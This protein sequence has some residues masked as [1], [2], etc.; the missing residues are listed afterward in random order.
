MLGE[1]A[2][3]AAA[4]GVHEYTAKL[5]LC[6]CMSRTLREYYRKAGFSEKIWFT[7]MCDLKYKA[8]ECRLVHGIW[9]SFVSEWFIRF[10]RMTRF[11][12]EK[13]QFEL[14]SFEK[15]Y[16][17]NG[18][19]LTPGSTVIN[20]HIPRT[21]GRLDEAGLKSSFKQA[22]AFFREN[23]QTEPIVFVCSS[24]LLFPKNLEVLS[25]SSNLYRF[26][27][28]FDLIAHGEYADYSQVWRLFD[29][30][31]QGDVDQLPQDTSFRRAYA[32]W[33]R[34]GE[35]TGWGDG[36]YVYSE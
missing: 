8:V 23:F 18:V 26:I 6:L 9:G 36:V 11:G 31:Y 3:L 12:F 4:V 14:I 7:C 15:D 1:A 19:C 20:V 5:L 33:I 29:K 25:P 2:A 34:K 27:S 28:L 13:L 21:G 24:W 10:F 22:A 35:K 32:D 30:E 16:A 17:K